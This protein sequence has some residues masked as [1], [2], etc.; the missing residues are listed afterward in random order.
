MRIALFWVISQRVMVIS[1]RRFGTNYRSHLQ[2]TII[3]EDGADR[4]SRKV[5]KKLPLL[6]A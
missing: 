4:L 2:W 6:A 3:P 1:Y 5:G